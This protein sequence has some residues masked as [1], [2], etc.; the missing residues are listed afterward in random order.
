MLISVIT[1]ELTSFLILG[2]MGL[3]FGLCRE[4][5]FGRFIGLV[6]A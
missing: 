1:G 2:R 5:K 3:L 4:P 6:A